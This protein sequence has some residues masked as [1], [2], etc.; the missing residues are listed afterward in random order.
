LII[1]S[2]SY[3]FH[4]FKPKYK[5]DQKRNQVFSNF[6]TDPGAEDNAEKVYFLTNKVQS[7]EYKIACEQ[8]RSDQSKI[9]EDELRKRI[10]ELDG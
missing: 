10:I 1:L 8:E 5:W 6:I 9:T 2:L 3:L 7:L 4:Y